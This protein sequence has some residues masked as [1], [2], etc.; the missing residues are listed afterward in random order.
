MLERLSRKGFNLDARSHASSIMVMD[1]PEALEEV[2]GILDAFDLRLEELAE[3]GGGE[4]SITQRL[5]RQL[6]GAGWEKGTFTIVKTI[7]DVEAESISHEIDHVKE[8]ENGTLALEIEW[9]SKDTFYD[10]DLENFNRL[11]AE[12]AISAGII[13]TRGDSLQS[14]LYDMMLEYAQDNELGSFENLVDAGFELTSKQKRNI[15]NAMRNR[16]FEE[17]WSHCFV[18]SKFGMATTHWDKLQLRISRRVGHPCPLLLIG[19]PSSIVIR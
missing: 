17:A 9:N 5:R 14:G 18:K 8:F 15:Q 19:I 12:S 6:T 13:I 1:F 2:E 16:N 7:N 10:R 4:S 3:G 11:H